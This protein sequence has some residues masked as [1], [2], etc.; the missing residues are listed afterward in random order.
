MTR[1]QRIKKE[2][3]EN[4][5]KSM[6]SIKDNPFIPEYPSIWFRTK[7]KLEMRME[8]LTN[9]SRLLSELKAE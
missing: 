5:E 9:T 3:K 6:E 1:K 8:L 4:F 7:S 2:I